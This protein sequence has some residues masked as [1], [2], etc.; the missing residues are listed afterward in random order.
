MVIAVFK[1]LIKI[2]SVTETLL[3]IMGFFC[4]AA[5]LY[6]ANL[7]IAINPYADN[8]FGISTFHK[9]CN[10]VLASPSRSNL[11]ISLRMSITGNKA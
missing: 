6:L 4:D 7:A 10:T 1:I 2:P 9:R 11:A 5:G 8:D 3:L